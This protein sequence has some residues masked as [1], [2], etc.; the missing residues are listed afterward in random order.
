[1]SIKLNTLV[2]DGLGTV[3]KVII[4]DTA[5][6]YK[7]FQRLVQNGSGLYPDLPAEIKAFADEVTV[8]R[9]LQEYKDDPVKVITEAFDDSSTNPN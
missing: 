9:I 6:S 4:I 8:G 5:E 3:A 1:M 2:K 7:N